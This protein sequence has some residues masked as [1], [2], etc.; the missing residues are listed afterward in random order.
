MFIGDYA[1]SIGLRSTDAS[2]LLA[3]LGKYPVQSWL[4]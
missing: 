2:I 1:L 3:L 4:S